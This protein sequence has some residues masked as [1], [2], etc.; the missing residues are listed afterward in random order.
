MSKLSCRQFIL[1]WKNSID[2]WSI[3]I[4]IIEYIEMKMSE[5]KKLNEIMIAKSYKEIR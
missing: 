3:E 1:S 5:K 4:E 2:L